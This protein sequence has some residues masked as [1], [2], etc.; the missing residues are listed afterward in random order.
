MITLKF[1]AS[2]IDADIHAEEQFPAIENIKSVSAAWNEIRKMRDNYDPDTLEGAILQVTVSE[3]GDSERVIYNRIPRLIQFVTN[4]AGKME[5][6]DFEKI[7]ARAAQKEQ[8]A[9]EAAADKAKDPV[10]TF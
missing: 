1:T 5:F 2:R 6:K 3:G 8:K 10:E 4:K 9:Q 7:Q